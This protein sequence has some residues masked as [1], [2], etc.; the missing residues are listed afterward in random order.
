MRDLDDGLSRAKATGKPVFLLFQEVPGCSG[1]QQFGREVLADPRMVTA[2]E[3]HFVP[4]FIPNNQPGKAAEVLKRYGEPAWNFQVVRFLSADGRDLIPREDKVWTVPA[5]ARRMVS[6]LEKAGVPASEALQ[7]LAGRSAVAPSPRKKIAFAQACFWVGEMQLGQ[8]DGVERT[9][10]GFFDGREVTLVEYDAQ[11]VSLPDLVKAA[12]ARDCADRI[13]AATPND[14]SSAETV[15]AGRR[16]G[17]LDS[18][19]RAAPVADQ[20]RQIQGTAAQGWALTPEQATKVNAFIRTDPDRAARYRTDG[21][22]S[23]SSQG[24]SAP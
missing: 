7:L 5:L 6:S 24:A 20:K 14:K 8:I 11:R 21:Q 9:E 18:S 10:A 2:I 13:Y 17:L 4:V 23:R 15:A 19:Y 16:V 12:L 22:A 3:T 1:C